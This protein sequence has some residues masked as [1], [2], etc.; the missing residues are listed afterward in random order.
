M[1]WKSYSE[2][3]L[4]T[5]IVNPDDLLPYLFLGLANEAGE[6]SGVYKKVIR[7]SSGKFGEEE[8]EK[9]V[10]E[11]GDVAWYM[12]NILNALDIPMEKVLESNYEKLSS[13][14]ERNVIG[15]SGDDR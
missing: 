11:M 8:K 5:L 13:R 2:F 12:A 7:D 9:L 1:D 3:A 15:G 14:K 6:V 10:K 4:T